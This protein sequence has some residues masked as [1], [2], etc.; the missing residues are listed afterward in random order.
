MRQIDGLPIADLVVEQN[1]LHGVLP[2]GNEIVIDA[3][4]EEGAVTGEFRQGPVVLRL[5]L[6]RDDDG[7]L[8]APKRPQHPSPP[9]PYTTREL[10]VSHPA[11]HTLAGTLTIPDGEKFGSGP[12]ATAVLITGGGQENRDSEALGHKPFLVIADYLTRHGVAVFRYDDR[13]VAASQAAEHTAVG[14]DATS[15]L[16]AT[17]AA[18][19]IRRVRDE[20]E[21]DGARVGVIGHSEGGLI[22]PLT[23][24]MEPGVAFVVTLAGPGAPLGDV[25][26]TQFEL[27]WAHQGIDPTVIRA[28]SQMLRT[29]V[30]AVVSGR[31]AE[32]LA[33]QRAGLVAAL[34]EESG[35]SGAERVA[36]ESG[37]DVILAGFDSPWWRFA[38]GFDPAPVLATIRCPVLALNG[39]KDRQ[40]LHTQNLDAIESAVMRGGGDVTVIRYDGMNHLFQPA[41]TG[42]RDEYARIET[43]FD[44]RVLADI[45]S[46]MD[47]KGIR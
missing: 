7:V 45:I 32:D 40:V 19:V 20:P 34:M 1:S 11:G 38:L 4:I 23:T 12:F 3:L 33:L 21:V 13:G 6:K 43:T 29:Y 22:G 5:D 41:D 17:D 42:A 24:L 37:M 15:L 9:Y 14:K 2:V 35:L 8:E 25:F 39:T 30:E 18:A 31:D 28:T 36:L 10:V 44:E 46:W 47:E 16:L 27:D 26:R